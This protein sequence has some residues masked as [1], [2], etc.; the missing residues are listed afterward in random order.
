M[1]YPHDPDPVEMLTRF[2]VQPDK[3]GGY[4]AKSPLAS[5]VETEIKRMTEIIALEV[6][7]ENGGLADAIRAKAREVVAQA[8][9]DDTYLNSVITSALAKVLTEIALD[10][11]NEE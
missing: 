8:L 9:H 5:R 6:V 1:G 10:R 11:Q 7:A 4:N 3:Y 2:L